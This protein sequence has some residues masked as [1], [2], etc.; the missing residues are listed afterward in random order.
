MGERMASAERDDAAQRLRGAPGGGHGG[1]HRRDAG[2]GEPHVG[3][4]RARG[5]GLGGRR[6]PARDRR[7]RPRAAIAR[8][9][10]DPVLPDPAILPTWE[11]CVAGV[12]DTY[13]S[14]VK[15]SLESAD[16]CRQKET[17]MAEGGAPTSTTAGVPER[18][19]TG[20][21]ALP[22]WAAASRDAGYPG[23]PA[24]PASCRSSATAGA[25]PAT[26]RSRS[27]SGTSA[28]SCIV[29]PFAALLLA[30]SRT[31]HQRLGA[32][33]ALR[34]DRLRLL[35][36]LQP[37]DVDPVR[38]EPAR[39]D[40][41]RPGR[42]THSF[43]QPNSMLPVSPHFPGLELATAGVHWLTGLPLFV[44]QVLVVVTARLTFSLALFLLASRIG[45]S[46][47]VGA[48]TVLLYAGERPV[49]LLQRPVLAT[50]PSRSRW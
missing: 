24:R 36:P 39:H 41:G 17:G 33:L 18:T 22:S 49:L 34:P 16:A 13:D 38:R 23:V 4:H 8:Q 14:I 50:R 40:A 5:H 20:E 45:R 6:R 46:T 10:D 47:A 7:R 28:S 19:P 29:A 32:S 31:G 9:L 1:A 15:E 12:A 2:R 43:F 42:R 44:C 30:P 11:T 27:C 26:S 3:P 35:A 37:A 25:G 21:R 48:A